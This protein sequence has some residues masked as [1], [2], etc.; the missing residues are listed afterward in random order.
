MFHIS[1]GSKGWGGGGIVD[2]VNKKSNNPYRAVATQELTL[3][4]KT[5]GFSDIDIEYE[6]L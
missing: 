3:N 4:P 6:T 1:H 2:G 5:W